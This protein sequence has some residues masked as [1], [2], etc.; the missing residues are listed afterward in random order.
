VKLS[1][2]TRATLAELLAAL[3]AQDDDKSAPAQQAVATGA[4]YSFSPKEVAERNGVSKSLVYRDIASGKLKAKRVGGDGPLRVMP[5][6]E[7]EYI[8]GR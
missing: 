5:E 8:A 7:A 4:R 1:K 2:S 6:D 3:L